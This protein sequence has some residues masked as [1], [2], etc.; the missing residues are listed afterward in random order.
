MLLF[1]RGDCLDLKITE[2]SDLLALLDS[3]LEQLMEQVE[4]SLDADSLGIF[5]RA[6]YFIG[7]GFVAIQQY[8]SDTMYKSEFSRRDAL[9]L[10][11]VTSLDLLIS[12]SLILL[13]IGG[14]MSQ[15]GTG[16]VK[17]ELAIKPILVF[18]NV[19]DPENYPL[20]NVLAFSYW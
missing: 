15:S 12:Q 10:G 1:S 11:A 5:D 2:L 4:S 20:S 7:V 6:E 8:I 19:V 18:S 16:I 9:N 14:N 3:K 13:Q 17:V